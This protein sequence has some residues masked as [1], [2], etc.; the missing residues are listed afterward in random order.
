MNET[1]ETFLL[2]WI[3]LFVAIDPLGMAPVFLGIT[4]EIEPDARNKVANQATM[5]AL[6]AGVGFMIA[7]EFVLRALG[8]TVSDFQIAGG[9][10]LLVIAAGHLIGADV[11]TVAEKEDL[12]VVPLGLPLIAG[13]AMFTTLLILMHSVGVAHTLAALTLN[14]LLL[15]L[16]FRAGRKL[17]RLFGTT[18]LRAVSKVISLFLAAYAVSIIRQGVQAIPG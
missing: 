11:V 17:E 5:T 15:N 3:P 12:G 13:P 1:L 18:G 4:A 8:I 2:A 10:I 6:L 16:A 9:L 7:G 14:L